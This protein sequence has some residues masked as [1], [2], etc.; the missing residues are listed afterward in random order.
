MT[1]EDRRRWLIQA[2]MDERDDMAGVHVPDDA[3]EQRDLLRALMNVRPPEPIGDEFLQVQDAYLAERLS[4]RGVVRLE[5]LAPVGMANVAVG[6]EA[7]LAD[8]LY[9]WRGDITTLATDAIVNA[10]NSQ[11]LGCFVPGH[12]CIDNAIHTFAGVQL[13]RAC[14]ELMWDQGHDE[15]T[16][17]VKV[18]PGFNLPAR[19][20]LHTVGPIVYGKEPTAR[21]QW[22]L[23]S[24]YRSCLEAATQLG[25]ASIALCCVSTG[26]FHY[27]NDAAAR[28]AFE[29]MRHH[30]LRVDSG[31][32]VVFNVFLEKDERIY[33][34]LLFGDA[35]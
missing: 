17:S 32:R 15:P 26:V 12:H 2:L 29:E 4:Q 27:P 30:L 22:G 23:R 9:L 31:L 14:A 6:V 25:C 21:D 11:M 34:D 28:V 33:R 20:V 13:R 19:Y 1:Q 18:T 10:A 24:S 16:G 35:R 5:D 7:G 3:Q 8:R